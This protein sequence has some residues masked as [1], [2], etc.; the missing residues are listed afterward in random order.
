MRTL[1]AS[2]LTKVNKQYTYI[3]KKMQKV[4]SNETL[5]TEVISVILSKYS[6]ECIRIYI[7]NL[8]QCDAFNVI[9]SFSLG[10]NF[11]L[12]LTFN[13]SI[14]NIQFPVTSFTNIH[15]LP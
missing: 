5:K 13:L 9:I 2:L 10:I 1:M 12:N 3:H 4:V 8:K 15:V 7:S 11:L 14:I 6:E